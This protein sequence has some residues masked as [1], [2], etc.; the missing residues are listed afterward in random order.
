MSL[1]T[2]LSSGPTV[3]AMTEPP[4]PPGDPYGANDPTSG[5]TPP[6]S[7]PPPSSPA[8]P[9]PPTGGYAPPPPGDYTPPPSG[10]YVPPPGGYNPPPAPYGGGTQIDDRTWNLINH[11]GGAAGAFVSAGFG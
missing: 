5:S 8:P 9:P 10:G 7:D 6:P 2:V 11:F 4:R 3:S 1:S